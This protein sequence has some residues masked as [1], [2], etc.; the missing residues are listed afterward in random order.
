MATKPKTSGPKRITFKTLERKMEAYAG[1]CTHC[2]AW[3][4]ANGCE[5]DAR[6]Y[7]C[8]RCKRNSVFGAEEA[9][10]MGVLNFG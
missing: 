5:P 1:F 7:A 3:T 9:M 10:I 2:Q 6:E 8:P 4:K